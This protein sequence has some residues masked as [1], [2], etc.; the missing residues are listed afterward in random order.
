M[1]AMI[2]IDNKYTRVY[3]SI[4]ERARNRT[5]EIYTERHHIIP[6]S[7]GGDNSKSNLVAL[8]PREHF[9]CHRLLPKMLTG[10]SKSKMIYALYCLTYVR[11]KGQKDRHIPN[12]RL[13]KTIKEGW[14][15]A[16][17]GRPTHNKGKPMSEEQKE[18][19]RQANLG[20]TYTRSEEYRLKQSIAQKKVDR[21]KLPQPPSRK[22]VVMPEEQKEKIRQSML[23]YRKKQRSLVT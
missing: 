19:L 6:K 14:H 13:Y 18:K 16:M 21:S 9:I 11:N 12:S 5:L 20:K 1:S 8:T 10:K 3:Y 17:K 7:L 4:I 23:A 2:F 22:G 15:K